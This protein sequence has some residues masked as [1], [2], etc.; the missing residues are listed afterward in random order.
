VD[1]LD[2]LDPAKK[3]DKGIKW[4]KQ[5]ADR[6]TLSWMDQFNP[7]DNTDIEWMDKY[8]EDARHQWEETQTI[9]PKDWK[10]KHQAGNTL[11]P[12][13]DV[14]FITWKARFS[15]DKGPDGDLTRVA[16]TPPPRSGGT[17]LVTGKVI[18]NNPPK[19]VVID[20]KWEESSLVGSLRLIID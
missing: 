20:L 19:A 8:D 5:N 12:R 1:H 2:G 9:H 13:H 14:N 6:R 16:R 3:T 15:G 17:I 7:P 18:L 10:T 11:P 4:T